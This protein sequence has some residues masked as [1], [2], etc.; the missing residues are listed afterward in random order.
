MLVSYI[1]RL[2][3]RR[4]SRDESCGDRHG[5]ELR[6]ISWSAGRR[7]KLTKRHTKSS[8][9][10]IL[11]PLTAVADDARIEQEQRWIRVHAALGLMS[12][13]A[14]A[15]DNAGCWFGRKIK[16]FLPPAAEGNRSCA[17]GFSV[18]PEMKSS[19]I[20]AR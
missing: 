10:T 19:P 4:R 15:G 16:T 20:S 12:A 5:D 7:G 2:L 9:Q 17:E 14:R 6:H 13:A 3:A 18:E 1:A 8:G 11:M